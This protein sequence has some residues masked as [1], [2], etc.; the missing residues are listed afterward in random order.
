[1]FNVAAVASGVRSSLAPIRAIQHRDNQGNPIGESVTVQIQTTILIHHNY[2][3]PRPIQ[4][5]TKQMGETARYDQIIR[6]GNRW[7]LFT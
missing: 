4:S 3:R 1:M 5:Y 7:K 2:S 6:G